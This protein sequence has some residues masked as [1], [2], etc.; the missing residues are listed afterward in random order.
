[1]KFQVFSNNGEPCFTV[2]NITISDEQGVMIRDDSQ[3]PLL[4]FED[5]LTGLINALTVMRDAILPVNKEAA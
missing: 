1:M 2:E 4:V 3:N 5:E